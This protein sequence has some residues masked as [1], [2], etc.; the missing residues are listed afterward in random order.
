MRFN[1]AIKFAD[2]TTKEITASTPDMVAFEDRFDISI[3]KI[4]VEQKISHLLY[5]AWHSEFRTKSTK[6]AYAEW[7]ETVESVG[8][9]AS[10][11]K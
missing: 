1:L 7:I 2:G 3:G 4:A 8:E 6:L 5:L 10:D 11:P 9:G